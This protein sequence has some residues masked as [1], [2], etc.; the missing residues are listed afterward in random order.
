MSNEKELLEAT[1]KGL[2]DKV[3]Q[4]TTE[5]QTKR[6]EL[7]DVSKPEL[8][9][10]TLDVIYDCV[11]EGI[12]EFNFS[13]SDNYDFE[14]EIDYDGRVATHNIEF[15]SC[16]YI[17]EPIIRLIENKFKIIDDTEENSAQ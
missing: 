13:D 8:N 15:N 4:L 12:E 9:Q 16:D 6:K 17:R 3:E 5:L 14:Y 7:E 1:V 10:S 2:Q 11:T